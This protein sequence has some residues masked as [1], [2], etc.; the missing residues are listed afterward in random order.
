MPCLH[1][2]Q[3]HHALEVL[4][5]AD[6]NLHQHGV[7]A[8]LLADLLRHL[9]W[10]RA[11]AIH[12]VDER[13]ARNVVPLHLA[14]DRHRLRLHATHRA[15]HQNRAVEHAQAAFHFDRE[16]HVPRRIDQVNRIA[17]PLEAGRGAGDRDAALFF[18]LH[19]V[20]R[21]AV[22][23][24]ADVL[25]FVDTAGVKQDPLAQGRFA[26]V[27]VGRDADVSKFFEVRLHQRSVWL[28]AN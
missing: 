26:R 11:R 6:R 13:Q 22:A 19:E 12:L 4:L 20:H 15:E 24:A 1:R 23:A 25:N 2:D 18:E 17:F 8:Q 5:A 27:D 10:V 9:F 7:G 16:V 14:V 28:N 3:V 21:G